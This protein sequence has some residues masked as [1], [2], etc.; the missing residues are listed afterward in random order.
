MNIYPEFAGHLKGSATSRAAADVCKSRGKQTREVLVY[1][2]L[3]ERPQTTYELGLLLGLDREVVV[4]RC[5]EM[6]ARGLLNETGETRPGKFG[7]Q[8]E[9]LRVVA[10]YS[11]KISVPHKKSV[12]EQ[13]LEGAIAHLRLSPYAAEYHVERAISLISEFLGEKTSH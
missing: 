6:K 2:A 4:P 7:N 3:K 8:M 13:T 10:P 9:V 11:K 1:E 5:S 12:K